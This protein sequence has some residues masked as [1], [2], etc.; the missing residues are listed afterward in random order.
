MRDVD[1]E[2]HRAI[3]GPFPSKETKIGASQETERE[4]D[5]WFRGCVLIVLPVIRR[6]GAKP[7]PPTAD[8][9]N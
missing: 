8:K 5:C 7:S 9:T 1:L 3:I 4:G 6:D 2:I